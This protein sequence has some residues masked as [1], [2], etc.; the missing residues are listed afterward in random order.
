MRGGGQR[1]LGCARAPAGDSL[2]GLFE[3]FAPPF[4]ACA[5]L[6]AAS[7]RIQTISR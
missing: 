3:S 2:G 1:R 7:V 6:G 4:F 5:D